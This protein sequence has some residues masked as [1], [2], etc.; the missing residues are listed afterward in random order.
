MVVTY[1]FF[2][3]FALVLLKEVVGDEN[4]NMYDDVCKMRIFF[5]SVCFQYPV[6][7]GWRP[8]F[9]PGSCDVKDRNSHGPVNVTFEGVISVLL[10]IQ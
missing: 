5:Y 4:S 7:T 1:Y 10:L 2:F 3:L 9:P 8:N 6:H